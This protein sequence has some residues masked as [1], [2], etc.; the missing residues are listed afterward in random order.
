[1]IER[2]ICIT[3]IY[4]IYIKYICTSTREKEIIN[5]FVFL[6]SVEH[7]PFTSIEKGQLV[8]GL[9]VSRNDTRKNIL[10]VIPVIL[11]RTA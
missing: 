2:H 3:H 6:L 10:P 1:M 11:V 9:N 4:H 5:D 8:P 7:D